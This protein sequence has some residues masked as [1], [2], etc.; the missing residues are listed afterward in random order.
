MSGITY[1][2]IDAA[3]GVQW[4]CPADDPEVPLGGTAR[5]YADGRFPNPSGRVQ[6]HRAVRQELR[7]KPRREFPLLLNTGRTVEHWHTRTKT[8]RVPLLDRLA[9]EAWVEMNEVDGDALGVRT[10]DVV[11]VT[12][13][14]GEIPRIIVRITPIV[15]AGEVFIPFHYDEACANRLTVDEFDPISRE[16]NFKQCAVRIER[17]EAHPR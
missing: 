6:L 9:P 3:G 5:L 1:E 4:P 14:R 8:A 16:P 2:R 12:S 11:R 15:R 7:D 17:A 13:S 10:G